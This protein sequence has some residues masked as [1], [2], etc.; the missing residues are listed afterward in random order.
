[1]LKEADL[2]PQ[3]LE[4]KQKRFLPPRTE[5]TTNR[6]SEM[7]LAPQQLVKSPGKL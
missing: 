1:M 4:S 7:T 3:S 6:S 5:I 2:S